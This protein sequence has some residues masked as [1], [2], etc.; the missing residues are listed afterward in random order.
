MEQ[1][2]IG[3]IAGGGGLPAAIAAA[4]RDA[5]LSPFVLALSGHATTEVERFPHAYAGLGQVS[6]MLST[7]RREKCANLVLAGSL[8]RPNLLRLRI[9]GGFLRHLPGILRML[10]G[11]D[12]AALRIVA[13]FFEEQGFTIKAA[14][15]IAPRLLAPA[16][17]FSNARPDTEAMRDIKVGLKAVRTLG[18]LDIGQAAVVSRG[19]VL[20]VEAAEGTD[21]MLRR[22]KNLNRWGL[23]RRSGVMVKGP[24]PRQDLRFDLPAV[25]PKTVELAAEAGLGGLAV[26]AG[27]VLLLQQEELVATADSRGL[28]LYGVT[29]DETMGE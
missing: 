3:I 11:G 9:D 7:L 25:G 10:K 18:D 13:R 15:E 27:A 1:E 22:C 14:Q 4:A 28:F 24:K 21:D 19:Y 8:R 29:S 2:R 20:A 12:D 16:G 26:A 5:G 23:A 17:A 6:R